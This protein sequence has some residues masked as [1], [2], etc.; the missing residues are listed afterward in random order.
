MKRTLLAILLSVV[1]CTHRVERDPSEIVLSLNADPATLNPILI[2]EMSG[3]QVAS[4]IYESLF[5]RDNETLGYKP[6]LAESW[7]VSADKLTYTFHLRRDVHWHDGQPFT[8]DDVIFT[9]AKVLDPKVD[10]ASHRQSYR[11]LKSYKKLDDWTVQFTFGK[12]YFRALLVLGAM[13][14]VPKHIFEDG[15]FNAHA[16]NRF[17]V[18]TGPYR[19]VAWKTGERLRLSRNETYWGKK[20]RITGVQFLVIPDSTVAFQLFKKGG[21]DMQDLR[22]VQWAKQTGSQN[23]Q[24][25]F[26]KYRYYLPN[27]AY[28]G[29]NLRKPLFADAKVRT[30]L[31]MAID[32]ENILNKLLFRQG[33]MVSGD[34]YKWSNSYDSSL[35]PIPFDPARAK[36]LLDEAGWTD[37]DGDGLRDRDGVPF[38]FNFLFPSGSKFYRSLGLIMRS[39]LVR[40]GI[41]MN[42]QQLEWATMIKLVH[43]HDFDAV[44]LAWSL[45]L[46]NDPFQIWHSSQRDRG[47]N[48]IGFSNLEV[49][50]LLE[51]ARLEYNDEK[52]AAMY[53][54]LHR[55]LYD[56]QPVAFLFTMPT[57]VA[58]DRRFIDVKEYKVGLDLLEWGVGSTEKLLAW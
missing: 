27:Y 40:L 33:E 16:A 7:D 18:G 51:Q 19:F 45:P 31:A 14:I 56:E 53:R 43:E 38:R 3:A 55:I 6:K 12:P 20:P 48:A 26:A 28:I 49:D 52:R 39:E 36:Q 24:K 42:L 9:M 2:T 1:S 34:A 57:L 4:F 17:P 44:G 25:R 8:A 15:D 5:D 11:D 13:S 54:Q 23:F 46:D 21:I 47:S 35:P 22:A 10:A 30:A 41:D 32:R 58:V 50:R 37:H 29:W